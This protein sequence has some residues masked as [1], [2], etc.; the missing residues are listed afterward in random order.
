MV[1]A[2]PIKPYSVRS[3]GSSGFNFYIQGEYYGYVSASELCDLIHSR[4][5]KRK[6]DVLASH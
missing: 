5:A 3:N 6:D 4:K 1:M 2:R